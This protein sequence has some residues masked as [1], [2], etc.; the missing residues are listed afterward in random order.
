VEIG[1]WTLETAEGERETTAEGTILYP[2]AYYVYTP[3]YQWLDNNDEAITLMDSKGEEVG[4]T[5]VVMYIS[6]LFFELFH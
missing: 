1:N 6:P 2:G 5:S 3:P 4:K